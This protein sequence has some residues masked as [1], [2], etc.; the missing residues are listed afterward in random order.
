MNTHKLT[1]T[2]LSP[3]G[4]AKINLLD[5]AAGG[6]SGYLDQDYKI[7]AGVVIKRGSRVQVASEKGSLWL[8]VWRP[9]ENEPYMK[10]RL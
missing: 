4:Q 7:Q 9:D 2:P 10:F 5:Q 6:E 8:F 1:S 3:E